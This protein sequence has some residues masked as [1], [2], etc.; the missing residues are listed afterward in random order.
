MPGKGRAVERPY[1]LKERT[2]LSNA[3]PALGETTFDVHLNGEAFW[4]NIPAVVWD[5]RLSGCQMLK[6]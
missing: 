3:L 6:K 5:Y 1:T 2:T 4:R